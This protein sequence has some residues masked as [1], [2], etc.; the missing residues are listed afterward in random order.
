MF[1]LNKIIPLDSDYKFLNLILQ[2]LI[3][4]TI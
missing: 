2:K 4:L 1:G 3:T